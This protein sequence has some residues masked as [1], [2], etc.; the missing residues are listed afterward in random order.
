ML[1]VNGGYP[2]SGTVLVGAIVCAV[3][4]LRNLDWQRYNPQERRDLPA[5]QDKIQT[6]P[7]DGTPL[8]VHTHIADANVLQALADRPDAVVFWNHR[9]PRDVLVS[10]QKLHD[11]DFKHA[12]TAVH[13]Y[14]RVEQL[15][16]QT[17]LALRL[18]YEA[19]TK[20][21]AGLVALVSNRLGSDLTTEQIA[22]IVQDT[23]VP[24]HRDIMQKVAE[25]SLPKVRVLTT[26][27]RTLREDPETLIN[28]R[29]IQSGATGRWRQEL[30]VE[31]QK[32]VAEALGPFVNA[33]G[34]EA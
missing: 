1:I 11:L 10:L 33:L 22:R 27:T 31:D 6:W 13:V 2:R 14:A 29:H 25:E 34:Y 28:D 19:F 15:V 21:P 17:G 23:S 30:S 5:F 4:R 32:I 3:L 18:R 7:R 8:L 9:D 24:R 20:D 12:I 16:R 26:Q